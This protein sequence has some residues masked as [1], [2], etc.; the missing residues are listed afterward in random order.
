M[1]INTYKWAGAVHKDPTQNFQNLAGARGD[2]M[3][4]K[5]ILTSRYDFRDD[6]VVVLTDGDATRTA[7]LNTFRTHLIE[8]SAPGD[9]VLFYFAGHGSQFRSGT[10]LEDTIVPFDSRD[11]EGK[12]FD[13]TSS[14]LHD[15]FVSLLKKTQNV[16]S[17]LDTCHS[18][19][20]VRG[21]GAKRFIAVDTRA[22]TSRGTKTRGLGAALDP[23]TPVVRISAARAD[24][25]AEEFVDIT[26]D[27][28]KAPHG[29]MSFELFQE[30]E[31]AGGQTTWRDVM[32]RTRAEIAKQNPLQDP[33]I[34][35][36]SPDLLVFGGAGEAP[37]EPFLLVTPQRQNVLLNAGSMY[38]LASG[39]ELD[40]YPPGARD[41]TGKAISRV[42]V[43]DVGDFTS[44]ATVMSGLSARDVPNGSRAVIRFRPAMAFRFRIFF[45]GV[46]P[47]LADLR[48]TAIMQITGVEQSPRESANVVVGVRSGNIYTEWP[49]GTP[50]SPPV[51]IKEDGAIDHVVR[52]LK[53][54]FRWRELLTAE[55]ADPVLQI[56]V[57]D[58]A[59]KDLSEAADGTKIRL[60]LCNTATRAYFT[61]VVYFSSAGEI[62]PLDLATDG[63]QLA[64]GEC[65]AG[66]S[67]M[68]TVDGGRRSVDF[69]KAFASI[70][71]LDLEP[72]MGA[73]IRA[74]S[75]A[76]W[77]AVTQSLVVAPR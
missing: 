31:R 33:Q 35:A 6:D 67:F 52:Q 20:A 21:G 59:G 4:L 29:L 15:L 34:E 51:A 48:K 19:T 61:R 44:Q 47:V 76:Q 1:G 40:V 68:I 16:T 58:E 10:T 24:Q 37:R 39:T 46:D 25:D 71:K 38:A 50:M 64:A 27:G 8:P 12:V 49:D 63:M 69:F 56:R 54:W 30:L 77:S 45:D 2:A 53:A 62:T 41:F 70:D 75:T 60:V 65:G 17:I 23:I 5:S 28:K 72:F 22:A 32:D 14:E 11:P 43:V 55:G 36:P 7:I 3:W 57:K 26:A 42:K 13:I 9:V 66:G 73:A 74:A 18:D